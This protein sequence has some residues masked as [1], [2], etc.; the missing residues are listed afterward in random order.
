M[1]KQS[2][3][4]IVRAT[5]WPRIVDYRKS[6]LRCFMVDGR[7]RGAGRREYFRK[8]SDAKTRAEQLATERENHGTA[9]LNFPT[10]E[11]VMAVE[12]RELLAPWNR[13]IRDAA[14]HYVAWLK[15]DAAR[16]K[17]PLVRECVARFLD[18]RQL[19]VERGDLAP[20]S[21]VEFR[22][23]C[24]HLVAAV[25]DLRIVELDAEAVRTYLDSFPV[26]ARTRLNIR[27]R[28]SKFFSFCVTKKW[29]A[30]NPCA[31]IKIKVRRHEVV[32][33]TVEEAEHLLRRA[34]ASKFRDVLVPYV[35]LCLFGGLRPFEARQLK[36]KNINLEAG[37][38]HV[39]A[40]TSKRR[41]SRYVHLEPA[42]VAWLTPYAKTNRVGVCGPN[43]RKQFDSLL[44]AAG[45]GKERPWPQDCLRHTAASMLL[46]LKRN[47]ALV[48]EELGTSVEV[49]RRFYRQP[50]L[51][52]DALRFWAL[53]PGS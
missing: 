30:T 3:Y 16:S 5:P 34:E 8:A 40:S 51:R 39:L 53:A 23:C 33:L 45:Y 49:L 15:A 27:L 50:I 43:F 36:W 26:A 4:P 31:E 47:R 24:A 52:A 9:A 13:T 18:S 38:L 17:S 1:P 6:R 46:T 10:A 28:L 48:A 19:E 37:H 42:L 7:R 2:K 22:H 41:E 12:C 25:G 20:R 14:V 11:R 21:L 35:A 32:V 44:T 29:I